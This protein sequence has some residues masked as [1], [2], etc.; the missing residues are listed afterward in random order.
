MVV[1]VCG[2][3]IIAK[4]SPQTLICGSRSSSQLRVT[5]KPTFGPPQLRKPLSEK[6]LLFSSFGGDRTPGGTVPF[7]GTALKT[8]FVGLDA[9]GVSVSEEKP[10]PHI[11]TVSEHSAL[12]VLSMVVGTVV[13]QT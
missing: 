11:V 3:D 10:C 5:P 8:V 9:L 7:I 6:V 12:A 1:P 4:L 2:P 13:G